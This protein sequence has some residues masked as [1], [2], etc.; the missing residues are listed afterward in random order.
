[1]MRGLLVVAALI[2]LAWS[3]SNV[4]G[5]VE[6]PFPEQGNDQYVTM[7]FCSVLV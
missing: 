3:D 5:A 7:F 6:P 2:A 4:L 1:M